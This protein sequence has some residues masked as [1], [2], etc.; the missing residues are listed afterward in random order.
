ML[1]KFDDRRQ[2]YDV[3][4]IFQDGGHSAENL[5]LVSVL[6]MHRI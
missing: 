1:L 5:I 2:N 6:V 4:S 3:I